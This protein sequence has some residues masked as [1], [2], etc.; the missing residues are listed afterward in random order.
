M[1]ISTFPPTAPSP[2][3]EAL[4]VYQK[5]T[6]PLPPHPVSLA[7]RVG[8]SNYVMQKEDLLAHVTGKSEDGPCFSHGKN[9]ETH[10]GFVRVLSLSP[11]FSA[12]SSLG[13]LHSE[14]PLYVLR[15]LTIK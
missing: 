5:W 8:T 2:L 13:Q 11:Y 14:A 15:K 12:P 1:R 3:P 10:V 7:K 9:P 6:V 4:R